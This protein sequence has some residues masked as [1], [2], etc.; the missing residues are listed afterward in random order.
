MTGGFS[1]D[2]EQL[3]T[4]A[5]DF[6]AHARR[7]DE[8]ARTLREALAGSGAPWG[9]DAVGA[10]FAA[11]HTGAASEALAAVNAIGGDLGDL[12]TRFG[13]AASTYRTTEDDNAGEFGDLDRQQDV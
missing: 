6:P 12:G 7:A 8:V 5:G 3:G 1:A 9:N 13:A 4:R 10:S 2:D 11:A